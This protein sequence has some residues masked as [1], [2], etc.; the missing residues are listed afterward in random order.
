MTAT[1]QGSKPDPRSAT[2][3]GNAEAQ[4]R[5][6]LDDWTGALRVKDAARVRS[7]YAPG[8][9]QFNMAPPLRWSGAHAWDQKALQAWFD[10]FDGPIGYEMRD[11]TI[12]A[13]EDIA[14]C[15]FLNH[16]SAKAVNY[17]SFAMWNRVTLGFRKLDGR[18]L[19]THAHSSVPFYMDG[20]F[21]AAVDLE[22]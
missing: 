19:I 13:G 14:F 7:H 3:A 4:I 21:K 17:G 6:L 5:A 16:L 10:T 11:L 18:W 15:Y 22:P 8:D 1:A 9:V 20:S 12:A 2:A